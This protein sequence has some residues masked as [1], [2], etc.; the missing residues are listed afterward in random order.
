MMAEKILPHVIVTLRFHIMD[1]DRDS[2]GSINFERTPV[3]YN[4]D[5][6]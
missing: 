6:H 1:V 4:F 5:F 2:L 3:F